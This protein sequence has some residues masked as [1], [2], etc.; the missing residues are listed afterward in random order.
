MARADKATA[1]ADIAD[2]FKDATA[3]LITEYRGLTVA[4]LAELRRSLAGSA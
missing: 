4:N 1:V 2:Q 3:T